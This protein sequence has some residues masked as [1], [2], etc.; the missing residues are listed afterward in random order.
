M[1]ICNMLYYEQTQRKIA[2]CQVNNFLESMP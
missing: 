1:A 2:W